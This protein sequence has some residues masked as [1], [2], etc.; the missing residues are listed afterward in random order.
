MSLKNSRSADYRVNTLSC[1][2]MY[3]IDADC[4]GHFINLEALVI[5]A[6]EIKS[7]SNVIPLFISSNVTFSNDVA[8]Q[9]D[10]L[11]EGNLIAGTSG[12][13]NL[14]GNVN[15]TDSLTI[16]KYLTVNK[17]AEILGNL[18]IDEKLCVNKL[19]TAKGGVD[20]IGDLNVDGGL[21]VVQDALFEAN[22]II[23][24][25]STFGGNVTIG[26]LTAYT[27]HVHDLFGFS[28]INFRSP[29]LTQNPITLSGVL[30][31]LRTTFGAK[32]QLMDGG[33]AEIHGGNVMITPIGAPSAGGGK[34]MVM[35]G[36][37]VQVHGGNIMVTPM[38]AS[39][40]GGHLMVLDGGQ[41]MVAGG[42]ITVTNH[43]L[44]GQGSIEVLDEGTINLAGGDINVM[45][46]GNINVIGGSIQ[47]IDP[48]TMTQTTL[49]AEPI[50]LIALWPTA[51]A[52]LNY[53]LCQGQTLSTTT[54]SA[55]FAVLG[56]TFG[57]GGPG[58]FNLPDLRQRIPIGQNT[59]GAAPFNTIGGTGGALTTTLG[60][61]NM[62]A[63]NHGISDPG[64]SHSVNDPG[65]S[66]SIP[67]PAAS[68]S[69]FNTHA[70]TVS[71]GVMSITNTNSA[72]TGISING[73]GTGI[74]TLNNGSGTA[75]D[76]YPPILTL[77]YIIKYA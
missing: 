66:H 31:F 74:S 24:G 67:N 47:I 42:N 62:P 7:T 50:G 65:H 20:I 11:L 30:N 4:N 60:V 33:D 41:V 55:L 58:T 40:N 45:Q 69:S 43:S 73:A 54:Y 13:L 48:M 27:I 29:V 68:V 15:I 19:L 72:G 26:N 5:S 12:V 10:L 57:M 59:L 61:A 75:F 52:P 34:V 6:Q 49:S 35:D 22:V 71:T 38:G 28:P 14:V 21:T 64:H 44:T 51:V 46:G 76:T 17:D 39:V 53:L 9:M 3:I 8:I 32:V 63:H 56:I 37:D 1:G 77:N 2:D 70:I 16:G 23:T 18:V 36:G 25:E